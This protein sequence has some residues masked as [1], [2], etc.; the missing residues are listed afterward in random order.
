LLARVTASAIAIIGNLDHAHILPQGST[1]TKMIV[2][3]TT[4]EQRFDIKAGVHMSEWNG[5][6]KHERAKTDIG[7]NHY[8]PVFSLPKTLTVTGLRFEYVEAGSQYYQGG[9]NG[10]APGFCLRGI[11][12]IGSGSVTG[13][14]SPADTGAISA[15]FLG[16]WKILGGGMIGSSNERTITHTG[17]LIFEREGNQYKGTVHYTDPVDYGTEPLS[18]ISFINGVLQFSRPNAKPVAQVYKGKF[19]N[20]KVIEGVFIHDNKYQFYWRAERL[21]G[22]LTTTSTTQTP[23]RSDIT[24]SDSKLTIPFSETLRSKERGVSLFRD[25]FVN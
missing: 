20:D 16:E 10:D 23:Q 18:D 25:N 15:H 1:I 17:K 5:P 22:P 12:L 2:L 7:G 3:T 8:M 11:T 6:D 9:P 24:P 14:F 13:S 19:T 21:S 4:G